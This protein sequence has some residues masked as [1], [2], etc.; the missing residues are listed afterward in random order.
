MVVLREEG[1]AAVEGWMQPEG[2]VVF[3]KA[4]GV[5]FKATLEKDEEPKGLQEAA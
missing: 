1:S 5:L 4:G 2:I 3:H